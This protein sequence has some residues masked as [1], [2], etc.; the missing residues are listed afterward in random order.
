MYIT[1]AVY[2]LTISFTTPAHQTTTFELPYEYASADICKIVAKDATA[3]MLDSPLVNS[4]KWE[5]HPLQK[6]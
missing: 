3:A 6:S 4:V 2:L 1:G 5:C